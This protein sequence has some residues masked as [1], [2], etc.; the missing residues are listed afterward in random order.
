MACAAGCHGCCQPGLSVTAIEGAALAALLD[1]LPDERR[2][3]LRGRALVGEGERCAAL[4][5]DG[6]CAVYA[7]RPLICRSHGVPVRVKDDR[8]LP[9][10]E[11]CRLNFA[12]GLSSAPADTLDQTTLSTILAG[13]DAAHAAAT[14]ASRER[15]TI[16]A[17][18][19]R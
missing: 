17:L 5:P 18:L 16:V 9:V 10:V 8:H 15:V 1:A 4:D 14:G 6:R 19:A 3:A 11:V 13:L 2:A 7:A 12:D